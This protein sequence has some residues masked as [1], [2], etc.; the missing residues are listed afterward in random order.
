MTAG[1]RDEDT[2]IAA[3]HARQRLGSQ[4]AERLLILLERPE[5]ERPRALVAERNREPHGRVIAEIAS[6]LFRDEPMRREFAR[7]LRRGLGS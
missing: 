6:R 7:A 3:K 4:G 5:A 2:A 1:T